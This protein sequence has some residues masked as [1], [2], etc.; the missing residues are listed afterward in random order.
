M[1]T[2]D[3][4]A[5]PPAPIRR[6]TTAAA[7]ALPLPPEAARAA[8]AAARANE[9]VTLQ[10]FLG[11]VGRALTAIPSAW[12]KAELLRLDERQ[13]YTALELVEHDAFGKAVAQARGVVF[14]ARW[15]AIRRAF[16]AAGLP[17][18]PGVRVMLAAAPRFSPR[19]GFSLEVADID[20]G[21]TAGDLAMKAEAIRA[22]LR[23]EG[24]FGRN[25][26]LAPPR[27]FLRVAVIAP[28]R[29]AGLADF[30]ASAEPLRRAGLVAFELREAVFQRQDAPE[31][32]AAALRAVYAECRA[33]RGFCAVALLRG[34][35][36]A[37]DL[38]HLCDYGLARAVCL[39]PVPVLVG[40]GHET[41]RT[42]LDEVACL[43]FS[44]P[45]KVIGH[46]RA[47][48]CGAA[49][50]GARAIA[51]V[52]AE[53]GAALLRLENGTLAAGAAARGRAARLA[54]GAAEEVRRVRDALRPD[55]RAGLEAAERRL[56][57]RGRA[58]TAAAQARREAARDAVAALRRSVCGGVT[59]KL[60][61]VERGLAVATDAAET[62]PAALAR[63]ASRAVAAALDGV[64]AAARLRLG[65]AE[66]GVALAA[67]SAE[68]LD[69]RRL[70]RAGYAIL[71]DPA[72]GGVPVTTA[73]ALR[74]L[75]A[76][77][78]EL[79]DGAT[80]LRPT[81]EEAGP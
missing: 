17:L 43:S 54:E 29:A 16:G 30:E 36:A 20:P 24:L 50:G 33:G 44:T 71:R 70:L 10:A 1:A 39:T 25:R 53:A 76:V 14:A 63:E 5:P 38:A 22:R 72:A 77:V 49:E 18:R 52:R 6:P 65:A 8:V 40:I 9:P 57:E 79:A 81:P 41:D 74:A 59:A 28:P 80:I 3:D 12:V 35:G 37:A 11:G 60:R 61:P 78:A 55:A 31:R 66:A 58:V 2:M 46:I 7:F 47:T 13:R 34:G 62:A 32:I 26:A 42:L 73:A 56:A 45:S 67:A 68:A 48:V 23:A 4:E 75:P 51:A 19:Y 15:A 27:D 69:P 21:Y 64:R